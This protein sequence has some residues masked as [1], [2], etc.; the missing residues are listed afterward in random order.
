MCKVR[1]WRWLFGNKIPISTQVLG[2]ILTTSEAAARL[3]TPKRRA[4]AKTT[5][6][7]FLLALTRETGEQRSAPFP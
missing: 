5:A 4:A 6:S 3:Q 7:N 1:C 2:E